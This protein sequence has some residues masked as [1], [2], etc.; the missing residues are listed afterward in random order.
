[1]EQALTRISALRAYDERR[2]SA[3][4]H[5]AAIVLDAAAAAASLVAIDHAIMSTDRLPSGQSIGVKYARWLLPEPLLEK[6]NMPVE[7]NLA[8]LL[9]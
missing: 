3:S 2:S 9:R 7:M 6:P 1:V 5:A 8:T 4:Q